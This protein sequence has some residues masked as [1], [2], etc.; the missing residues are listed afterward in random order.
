MIQTLSSLVSRANLAWRLGQQYGG[1]R[2]IYQALGYPI[3]IGYADRVARYARQDIAAAIIDRPVDAT[4]SG[5]VLL[6]ESTD[7]DTPLEKDWSNL[8]KRRDLKLLSKLARLDKL[9]GLGEYAV[10]LYGFSDVRSRLDFV[11]PVTGTVQLVYVRPIG[12][13]NAQITQW[14]SDSNSPRFG[15][16]LMYN[17]SFSSDEGN[18]VYNISVHHSRILHVAD[19]VLEGTVKGASRLDPVWNRLMDLEKLVGGSSEMFWRGARPGYQA[20][21]DDDTMMTKEDEEGL[22]AQLDE[23]EHHLRRFL[24]SKGLDLKSLD[25]QLADPSAQV[26]VQIQMISAQT[27]IPKRILVGS[28]R[29]ELASSQDQEAWAAKIENRRNNF[30]GPEIIRAFADTCIAHGILAPPKSENDYELLWESLYEKSDKEKA[31]VGEIRAKALAQY[32]S[33]PTAEML[34]PPDAFYRYFLGFGE[35]EIELITKI[36]EAAEEELGSEEE[37]GGEENE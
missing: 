8:I 25:Q 14:E 30:V 18:N 33:Q 16:P 17:L 20:R 3:A 37:L 27:G 36:Q 10:L 4:W 32:A 34:V 5:G 35:P 31:E 29:G 7:E 1:D 13:G 24:V 21:M 15:M 19:N 26:D 23:Y 6:Q 22:Q 28:E 2:D 11:N 9:T 12:E